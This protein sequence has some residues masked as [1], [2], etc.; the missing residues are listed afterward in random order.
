MQ[1]DAQALRERVL[2]L[3]ATSPDERDDLL[4]SSDESI[5]EADVRVLAALFDPPSES[6]VA[7]DALR[8]VRDAGYTRDDGLSI[9]AAA[10]RAEDLQRQWARSRDVE[11]RDE[12]LLRLQLLARTPS[13]V[14]GLVPFLTLHLRSPDP[15]VYQTAAIA[16]G[17][18]LGSQPALLASVREYAG[19][20]ELD[21]AEPTVLDGN[22][23]RRRVLLVQAAARARPHGGETDLPDLLTTGLPLDPGAVRED[24]TPDPEDTTILV[25][26]SR[27]LLDVEGLVADVAPIARDLVADVPASDLASVPPILLQRWGELLG[28]LRADSLLDA[29]ATADAWTDLLAGIETVLRREATGRDVPAL[30]HALFLLDEHARTLALLPDDV[31]REAAPSRDS[32]AATH[33]ALLDERVRFWRRQERNGA[34]PRDWPGD[35]PA[36]PEGASPALDLLLRPGPAATEGEIGAVGPAEFDLERMDE[37]LAPL[38]DAAA[39]GALAPSERALRLVFLLGAIQNFGGAHD[40]VLSLV[41]SHSIPIPPGDDARSQALAAVILRLIRLEG[42]ACARALDSRILESVS[43]LGVLLT[44]LPTDEGPALAADLADNLE[45]LLRWNLQLEPG[46]RPVQVLV[47]TSV[48]DP[49]PAFYRALQDLVT[50]RTYTDTAGRTV[51]LDAALDAL[52]RD[53]GTADAWRRDDLASADPLVPARLRARERLAAVNTAGETLWDAL[54][55]LMGALG[56]QAGPRD[57]PPDDT[58][59]GI[60]G[61][62]HPTEGRMLASGPEPWHDDRPAEFV[63]RHAETVSSMRGRLGAIRPDSLDE[64]ASA[65]AALQALADDLEGVVDALLPVLPAVEADLLRETARRLE[66]RIDA[67]TQALEALIATWDPLDPPRSPERWDA[68]V[69]Q[70]TERLPPPDRRPVLRATVASLDAESAPP[71]SADPWAARRS[72]LA[73]AVTAPDGQGWTDAEVETW[74]ASVAEVWRELLADAMDT[75][76]ENRVRDLLEAPALETLRDRPASVDPLRTAREWSLDRYMLGIATRVR[77]RLP[78]STDTPRWRIRLQE[79]GAFLLYH[80]SVWTAL[81][82]GAILMEDFGTAWQAMAEQG[83]I[84]GIAITFVLAIAGAFGYVLLD[85]HRKTATSP[86]A[87]RWAGLRSRLTRASLFVAACWAFTLVVTASLWWLLSGTDQVVHGP[88]AVLHVIVWSSFALLAG[89][90]LGLVAKAT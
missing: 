5:P 43:D 68:L 6:F 45:H 76:R 85:L 59:L 48:R 12:V 29:T 16:V 21:L 66:T 77:T 42:A 49:H 7:R 51:P 54:D 78:A 57:Q 52:L 8:A 40:R 70:V 65:H 31:A 88:R 61:L 35:T 74:E 81:I 84:Q 47:R 86:G 87:R 73:W 19:A 89:I 27:L 69:E 90:F 71:E 53:D 2:E 39:W 72:F 56:A 1:D 75:G 17:H 13:I 24:G 14:E 55:A 38:G 37:L 23:T 32:L 50:R 58:L 10:L 64:V 20:R 41:R 67:Y 83:D 33:R 82:V 22:R 18:H 30:T 15:S 9:L 11:R 62:V 60:V 44:L 26:V 46:F 34:P 63:S 25:L 80:S 36:V 4:A 79:A 3:A 28:T